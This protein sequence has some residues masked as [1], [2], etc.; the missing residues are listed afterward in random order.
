M[1]C[2]SGADD[3]GETDMGGMADGERQEFTFTGTVQR[4]DSATQVV[5]VQNED[6]PGWMMSMTMSYAIEPA[7]LLPSLEPG[8][9]ITAKVYGGD[10]GKLYAV[11]VLPPQ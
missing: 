8:D 11:E 2:G 10:F 1:A 5:A 6:I 3:T 4:V 9:R 7:E